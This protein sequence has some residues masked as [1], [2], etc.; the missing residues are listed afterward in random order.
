M[1][2]KR[3]TDTK[4]KAG[5]RA[6]AK[7]PLWG[8]GGLAPLEFAR[9]LLRGTMED[10]LLTRAAALSFYF[11]FALFPI[12]LSLMAILGLLAQTRD[13]R[14]G[15]LYQFGQ[16][17]PPSALAL[18]EGTVKELSLHSSGWKLAFG[19]L[20]ALW[21]GSSGMSSIMDALDRCY[22]VR[23]SRSYLR[24]LLT[25]LAL[26]TTISALTLGALGI[27]LFGGSLVEFLGARI[28]LSHFVVM[29][30]ET[31]AWPIALLLVLF[32]L[33]LIYFVGPDVNARWRWLTPG[34]V[35]GVAAWVAASLLLRAYLHF[36]NNY[37]R[38]YGSLGAVMILLLWLYLTGLAILI[39]GKIDAEIENAQVEKANH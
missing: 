2:H 11:I 1:S 12:V 15:L 29:L 7:L 13:L 18:I 25:S 5:R 37:S 33:A 9:R 39:G 3:P 21:S 26:T 32:S 6:R 19:I 38:T 17:M 4:S 14:T 23:D 16:L 10:E 31:A 34:S 20:L 22:G 8:L 36:F 35:V 24:R 28:G 27:V 30:W